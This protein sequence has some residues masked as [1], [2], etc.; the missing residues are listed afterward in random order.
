MGNWKRPHRL[1][2]SLQEEKYKAIKDQP[3]VLYKMIYQNDAHIVMINE[4]DTLDDD[5]I[6]DIIHHGFVGMRVKNLGCPA[7]TC[8]VHGP[9]NAV[10]ID[11]RYTDAR[12]M[13]NKETWITTGAVFRVNFGNRSKA[14]EPVEFVESTRNDK[15]SSYEQAKQAGINEFFDVLPQDQQ[16]HF[17]Q[18]TRP[19]L[20][21]LS[22]G[23][24][25]QSSH[26]YL[27][28]CTNKS[29]FPEHTMEV[30]GT[31][32]EFVDLTIEPDMSDSSRWDSETDLRDKT[33]I[34][35][36]GTTSSRG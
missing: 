20:P 8:F 22:T 7:V 33:P 5:M 36:I 31:M 12:K 16:E 4:A 25:F 11:L 27:R 6:A 10:S 28:Q 3:S 9:P 2:R 14:S 17:D 30:L 32:Y 21:W 19:F 18:E 15:I 23:R 1:P 13:N 24:H 29:L 34:A 26:R 35:Y